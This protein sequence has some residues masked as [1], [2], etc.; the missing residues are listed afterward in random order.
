[1]PDARRRM[2]TLVLVSVGLFMVVLDNLVV[3]VAL[4]SIHASLGAS[5]Q[6]LEWT[7]NAY[8]LAYAVLLL[9]GAALGDRFGRKRMF[10]TGIAIFTVASAGA[11]LAPSAGML[12]VFRAIQGV[13][14]AIATPLTLTLLA[15]AYPPAQRGLA[16]GIWSG[17]SGI[18]VALGPL[19][20][21]AVI[22]L[23]SWH[24]IFWINVPVGL[25]L[26]PLAGRRLQ[27]SHGPA[28]RLD[29]AGVALGSTGLLGL[30]YGLVRSQTLGWGATEVLATLA[31]GTALMIAFVI[32]ERR[33]EQPMLPMEFFAR[34]GFAVT[35]VVSLSMYFGM[36]GSVFFLS[37]FLQ[38]VLGNSP[39]QAGVKLL[40]W[41]GAT[42]LVAP[43]AGIFSERFGS[44]LFMAAGLALQA[45]ALGWLA[46]EAS[47]HMSYLSMLGPFVLGGSGMALVFAPSANAVLASVRSDQAGQASGATNAIRELG[48]VLGI[49]VLATVF[50]SHGGYTS[51]QAFVDGLTPAL[52]IGTAVLAVGAILPIVL[53][54]NTRETALAHAAA[55]AE[56]AGEP[57]LGLAPGVA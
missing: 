36:F 34:R 15:D 3:S 17:I 6:A 33:T 16:L 25:A 5:V 20:G 40:G 56:E 32:H 10:M 44:R 41:T 49:A 24:D 30:V 39:L 37:Q 57:P 54:F 48:G 9:T 23:G 27:E 53:P 47:T 8:T 7:V 28:R 13:G 50:T 14:A 51:P 55:E 2:W 21:G 12:I 19:V 22:Q 46:A 4:P 42:L 52:W 31:A 45:I 11:A 18:A 1:M 26:V 38:T 29:L 43:L 35:N